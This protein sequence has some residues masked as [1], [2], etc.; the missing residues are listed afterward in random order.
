MVLD[1]RMRLRSQSSSDAKENI[2]SRISRGIVSMLTRSVCLRAV[3]AAIAATASVRHWLIPRS[4]CSLQMQEKTL[5]LSRLLSLRQSRYCL[6]YHTTT[7]PTH[8]SHGFEVTP[9]PVM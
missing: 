1:V 6:R 8:R 2:L 7:P 4:D 3:N 9:L 5:V